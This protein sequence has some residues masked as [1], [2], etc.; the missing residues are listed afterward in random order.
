MGNGGQ[1]SILERGLVSGMAEGED[2]KVHSRDLA[3]S[4]EGAS[5]L[6]T[7]HAQMM[8]VIDRL[9]VI[10]CEVTAEEEREQLIAEMM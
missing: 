2:S 4:K 3:D 6:S 9:K 8:G 10:P 5:S 1:Q 7:L